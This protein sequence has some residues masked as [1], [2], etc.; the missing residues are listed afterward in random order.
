MESLIQFDYQLFELINGVWH[1]GFFDMLFP[2]FRNKYV[3]IPFYIFLISFLLINFKKQGAFIVLLVI[4]LIATSDTVSS[5]LVK[6]TIKRER[7]CHM[8]SP[9]DGLRPLVHCGGGYS[10]TS[11]HATNHFALAVFLCL[12]LGKAFKAVRIPFLLWAFLI[13]YG[14]VY[15]GVHFPL[16]VFAGALLGSWLAF[17]FYRFYL[18]FPR[19]SLRWPV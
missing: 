17:L 3:W 15:V 2:F 6:K 13:A 14:Q 5:R 4:T 7:P 16:D 18:L 19:L 12:V 10:F 8:L 9:N 1:N 11:S